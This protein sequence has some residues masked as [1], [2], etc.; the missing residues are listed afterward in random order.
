MREKEDGLREGG[1]KEGGGRERGQKT[2]KERE[3]GKEEG[4]E[5]ALTNSNYY[6]GTT[7]YRLCSI[8][9]LVLKNDTHTHTHVH[10]YTD[11]SLP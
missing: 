1:R 10:M 11:S 9:S 8:L 4:M 6:S 7:D 3:R 2:S 5:G